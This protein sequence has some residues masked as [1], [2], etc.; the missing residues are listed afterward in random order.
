M[1]FALFHNYFCYY[2]CC[3]VMHSI[4]VLLLCVCSLVNPIALLRS[5]MTHIAAMILCLS[6][7]TLFVPFFFSS[8]C[9]A[10]ADR[11]LAWTQT[12]ICI[13]MMM[14]IVLVYFISIVSEGRSVLFLCKLPVADCIR[15]AYSVRRLLPTFSLSFRFGRD[16]HVSA[17]VCRQ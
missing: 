2:Y 16:V 7:R 15:L 5:T 11:K 10:S 8:V 13:I 3:S 1:C 17:I 4:Q 12:S 14:I 6:R 9:F